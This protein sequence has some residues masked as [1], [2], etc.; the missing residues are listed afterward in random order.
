MKVEIIGYDSGWGDKNHGCEDGPE[1][2]DIALILKKLFAYRIETKWRGTLGIKCIEK[3]RNISNKEQSLP[4]V[5]EGIRRLSMHTK[6]STDKGFIPLV[7][8]GDKSSTIGTWSGI[9][10][11]L[12]AFEN[13]GL[14]LI[15]SNFYAHSDKI[16]SIRDNDIWWNRQSTSALIGEGLEEFSTICSRKHKISPEHIVFI[17]IK[18]FTAE[19]EAFIK[20]NNIKTFSI[21]DIRKDGIEKIFKE[22]IDIASSNT[23]GFGLSI[24]MSAFDDKFAPATTDSSKGGITPN[25]IIPALKSISHNDKLKGIEITEFNPHNDENKKTAELIYDIITNIF[26][27]TL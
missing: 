13:F 19:E 12:N 3:S 21:D 24:D 10:S 18:D 1:S 11:S 14:I 27:K 15:S 22:A 4:L 9:V 23:S 6:M 16:N 17:G 2:I 20:I 7:I 8:G 5:L 25:E 26:A